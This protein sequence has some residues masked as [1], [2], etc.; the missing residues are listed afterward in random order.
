MGDCH[1]RFCERLGVKLP[2]PDLLPNRQTIQKPK[3]KF[4]RRS[5]FIKTRI[6][7]IETMV[8]FVITNDIIDINY[9]L[10]LIK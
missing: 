6:K 9:D 5:I 3:N 10:F 4:Y 2:L 8:I 1:V 7:T